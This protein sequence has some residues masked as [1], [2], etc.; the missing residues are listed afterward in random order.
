MPIFGPKKPVKSVKTTLYYG[1]KK[2]IRYP[3]FLIFMKKILLSFPYF[4]KKTSIENPPAFIPIYGKKNVNSAKTT[5]YYGPKKS[6]G[7]VCLFTIFTKISLL[8]RPYF[9]KKR[10]FSEKQTVLIFP[11]FVKKRPKRHFSEKQTLLIFTYFV[12]KTAIL[13]KT[14]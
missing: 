7:L 11:Y 5:L 12:K 6:K 3:F 1:T 14:Q 8:L 2:S 13:S 4:V 10:P 9:V